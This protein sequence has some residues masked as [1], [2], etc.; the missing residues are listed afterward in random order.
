MRLLSQEYTELI[1]LK[2]RLFKQSLSLPPPSPSLDPQNDPTADETVPNTIPLIPSTPLP[3]QNYVKSDII[4]AK[5]DKKPKQPKLE[6]KTVEKVSEIPSLETEKVTE[7]QKGQDDMEEGALKGVNE[8]LRQRF[9]I[10]GS[11]RPLQRK[12]IQATIRGEDVLLLMPTGGGKSICY[13]LP[14][15]LDRKHPTGLCITI[16]VT[17]LVSLMVDQ[18]ERLRSHCISAECLHSETPKDILSETLRAIATGQNPSKHSKRSQNLRNAE[19][20]SGGMLVYVTPERVVQSKRFMAAMQECYRHG[21][22]ARIAIDEAH[23][24]SDWGH[25]FRPDYR[26]LGILK[27]HFP[28]IS[29]MAVTATATRHVVKDICRIL[30]LSPKAVILKGALNRENLNYEVIPKA[31][32]DNLIAQQIIKIIKT[33][34]DKK[35][36]IVYC[37]TRTDCEA[38]SDSLN[39]SGINSGY[40]HADLTARSRHA[41]HK[42]WASGEFQVLCATIAFGMGIDKPDVRFVIHASLSKTLEGY[43]QESGRA[44]RDGAP[45]SC[46]LLFGFRDVFRLCTLIL[47]G[48]GSNTRA[49]AGLRKMADYARHPSICRRAT[50]CAHFDDNLKLKPCETFCDVCRNQIVAMPLDCT[51]HARDTL[52]ILSEGSPESK[53]RRRSVGKMTALQ[54]FNGVRKAKVGLEVPII[55]ALILHLFCKGH[56]N[57]KLR[58]TAYQSYA[59]LT[60]GS[61]LRESDDPM[62]IDFSNPNPA[63]RTGSPEATHT[64]LSIPSSLRKSRRRHSSDPISPYDHRNGAKKTRP[65]NSEFH[66]ENVFR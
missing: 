33:R 17:P 37:L 24:A 2:T 39:G 4:D 64:R 56:I 58:R 34:F 29:I 12:A 50:I 18:V 16:V 3:L 54:L 8:I 1:S 21:R 62:I 52:Q 47:S 66:S 15:L 59:L 55:E 19:D 5:I 57:V 25:D 51:G 45:A 48:S 9:G 30:K 60:L 36:G 28:D 10:R 22:L 61:P 38:L 63:M 14:S 43:V 35:S 41:V 40:Y 13:Q 42:K 26:A 65:S 11:L 20:E 23:C 7:E 32:K 44:G 53:A 27:E 46:I 31:R 49:I 6:R